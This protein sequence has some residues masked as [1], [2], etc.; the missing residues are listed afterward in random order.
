M[1]LV[2]GLLWKFTLLMMYD[3][4]LPQFAIIVFPV[5]C[6]SMYSWACFRFYVYWVF[7][8]TISLILSSTV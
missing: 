1:Y 3:R 5:K 2:R 8:F 6:L 7:A 4:L